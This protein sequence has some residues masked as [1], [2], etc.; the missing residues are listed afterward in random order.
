MATVNTLTS[1]DGLFKVVYGD[2]IVNLLP[3]FAKVSKMVPFKEKQMIGEQYQIP[4]KLQHEHGFTYAATGDGAFSLSESITGQM[5]KAIV[6]SNQIILR[7]KLDYESAYKATQ[8]GPRAFKDAT[9]TL[10]ENMSESFAKRL[11]LSLLYGQQGLGQISVVSG[12]N[13][14]TV[15]ISAAT[16]APGIWSGM[17]DAELEIFDTQSISGATQRA[18]IYTVVS[19]DIVNRQVVLQGSAAVTPVVNDHLYYRTARTATAYKEMAG[20][21]KILVN[22]GTLFNIDASQYELWK[23]QTFN[24]GG[25]ITMAQLQLALAQAVNFGL[26]EDCVVLLSPKRWS[27]LNN[28]E[29]ALRRYDSSY[30]KNKA[31]RGNENISYY[32]VSGKVDIIPHPFVKEGEGF[33]LP[34]KRLKRIGAT[35]ITFKRP[36]RPDNI[37]RELVDNA[38]FE[39]RQYCNQAIFIEA[40]AICVKLTGIT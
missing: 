5:K 38:G 29:A 6:N 34:M 9:E 36:N 23:A 20:I 30:D 32:G 40:P 12:T 10:I 18:A 33:I 7:S 17:K 1:L 35:D 28:D 22:T 27:N 24:V 26:N 2:N 31:E 13:P 39:L 11:E 37:F 4:V 14:Y 8:E 15:T 19:V 21:D 3:E 16:F 25:S